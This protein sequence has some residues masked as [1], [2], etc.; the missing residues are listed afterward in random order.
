M[1]LL[2][3]LLAFLFLL[4][5]ADAYTTILVIREGGY[6]TNERLVRL[7][8]WLHR[9]DIGGRWAWLAISKALMILI[10]WGGISYALK[11]YGDEVLLEF[12]ILTAVFC[13]WY[14]TIVWSNWQ[15]LQKEE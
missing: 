7:D 11:V 1:T 6:E 2:Y 3:A 8:L 14:S 15:A 5:L 9:H 12:V 10:W 13:A 4:Q